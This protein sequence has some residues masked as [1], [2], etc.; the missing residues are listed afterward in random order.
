MTLV[1]FKACEILHELG[2]ACQE[3]VCHALHACRHALDVEPCG[4][5]N[6]SSLS[7]GLLS[8][9]KRSVDLRKY[10]KPCGP[11]IANRRQIQ[12]PSQKWLPRHWVMNK[13][14]RFGK[15]WL[16]HAGVWTVGGASYFF[17]RHAGPPPDLQHLLQREEERS[18]AQLRMSNSDAKLLSAHLN[19]YGAALMRGAVPLRR[20]TA[21]EYCRPFAGVLEGITF[22]GRPLLTPAGG[23]NLDVFGAAVGS[24]ISMPLLIPGSFLAGA[25]VGESSGYLVS[26]MQSMQHPTLKAL[27]DA[28]CTRPCGQS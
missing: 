18:A 12:L 2:L 5:L 21:Q 1:D 3:A 8:F 20:D 28:A 4:S 23:L 10:G 14:A 7:H 25:L 27:L 24:A 22:Q 16:G 11:Y 15:R 17:Y 9:G 26:V 6:L 13:A 19:M